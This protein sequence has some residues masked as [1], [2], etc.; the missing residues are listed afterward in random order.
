MPKE[1]YQKKYENLP[2]ELKKALDD[3]KIAENVYEIGE[4]Y[5]IPEENLNE[6][7]KIAGEVISGSLAPK[8]LKKALMERAGVK[9]EDAFRIAQSLDIE[10]FLLLRPALE[11]I[12]KPEDLKVERK[13][14]PL[15]EE[16]KPAKKIWPEERFEAVIPEKPKR[17]PP[18]PEIPLEEKSPPLSP[19]IKKEK[20]SYPPG[21]DPYREPIEEEE[22]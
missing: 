3:E 21:Y 18:K 16:I 7:A 22:I 15:A 4:R 2:E 20:K 11:K 14:K 12:Y 6:M 5:K 1:D 9:E 13:I 19:S 8:D 10:I 17:S